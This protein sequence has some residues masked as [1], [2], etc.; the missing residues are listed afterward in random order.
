MTEE[1]SD[2]VKLALITQPK[3]EKKVEE[4]AKKLETMPDLL[5]D[6][7]AHLDPK[8]VAK[9][10]SPSY[11]KDGVITSAPTLSQEVQDL[12]SSEDVN[13]KATFSPRTTKG[14]EPIF[15]TIKRHTE[16]TN[17]ITNSYEIKDFFSRI[18]EKPGAGAKEKSKTL[19]EITSSGHKDTFAQAEEMDIMNRSGGKRS[20]VT[21]LDGK[22]SSQMFYNL[23]NGKPSTEVTFKDGSEEKLIINKVTYYTEKGKRSLTVT[24][25]G[26]RV[27]AATIYNEKTGKKVVGSATYTYKKDG[28]ETVLDTAKYEFKID[29]P[30]SKKDFDVELKID[31]GGKRDVKVIKNKGNKKEEIVEQ[32]SIEPVST[33]D[34]TTKDIPK[35]AIQKVVSGFATHGISESRESS[36]RNIP[37]NKPSGEKER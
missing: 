4:A 14:F 36:P 17:R 16:K 31:S 9:M 10:F 30:D 13:K 19:V 20:T 5:Q 28:E 37:P 35:D 1:L 21:F 29:N 18:M 24:V 22:P 3:I 8:K 23:K 15:M 7:L 26:G 33:Q 6:P 12:F 11:S 32:A 2:L 25:D 27:V 34:P